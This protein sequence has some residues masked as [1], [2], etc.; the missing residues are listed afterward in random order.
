MIGQTVS[1]YRIEEQLGEGGMGIVYRAVDTK[2]DR[3]VA[4][5]FLPPRLSTDPEAKARF[6]QEAKAASGLDHPN[7][8]TIYDIGETDD[9]RLFIAMAFYDGQTLKYELQSGA[10]APEQAASIGAQ[11][12]DG[13]RK[14]HSARMVHRDIK[15]A[16]IMVTAEGRVKILDFGVAKLAG[17]ADLTKEGST[18]GTT[19][20]MSPEQARGEPVDARADLWSLGVLLYEMLSGEKPFGGEYEQAVFYSVLNE[21][22][23]PL[24]D[25]VPEE[26]ADVVSKL[27]AKSSKDRYQS[28]NDVL[29]ALEPWADSR[30]RSAV[31]TTASE[32]PPLIPNRLAAVAGGILVIAVLIWLFVPM[33]KNT[34]SETTETFDHV[35]VL[36]FTVQGDESIAYLRD[37]MVTLLSGMLDGAGPIRSIDVNR[38]RGYIE[39]HPNLVIDPEGG[40]TIAS[41]LGA[42]RYVIGTVVQAGPERQLEAT[43]Y[44]VNGAS[45]AGG[46]SSYT[47]DDT[48]MP[49]V[50]ALARQ[51]IGGQLENPDT[52]LPTLA[53]ET[54]TSVSA[55][56]N[57]LL[58]E[59]ALRNSD[60]DLAIELANMAIAADSTF[61]LAW[62]VKSEAYGWVPDFVASKQAIFEAYKYVDRLEGSLRMLIE[63]AHMFFSAKPYDAER[64][65]R[66][67]VR[68]YPNDLRALAGLAET[69]LH[70]SPWFL[71]DGDPERESWDLFTR[72]IELDPE[73]DEYEYH[74]AHSALHYGGVTL[75]DSLASVAEGDST[76]YRDILEFLS[77]AEDDPRAYLDSDPDLKSV[78]YNAEFAASTD[79][80]DIAATLI[81]YLQANKFD[82]SQQ[83]GSPVLTVPVYRSAAGQLRSEDQ[84]FDDNPSKELRT[85]QLVQRVF[86]AILPGFECCSVSLDELTDLVENWDAGDPEEYVGIYFTWHES[87]RDYLLGLIS[88]R[89]GD[90][91][92]LEESAQTFDQK[93]KS[94][95]PIV[96]SLGHELK[97]LVSWAAGDMAGALDHFYSVNTGFDWAE[98]FA[99]I[100][101]RSTTFFFI[102]EILKELGRY[103]DAVKYLE[104]TRWT[105]T[106]QFVVPAVIRQAEIYELEG[107]LEA[108]V[109]RYERVMKIWSGADAELQPVVDQAR[110]RR[111]EL[112]L[113]LGREPSDL[114]AP[115]SGP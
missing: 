51:L 43:L 71:K 63:G 85:H 14:A 65:L 110:A 92:A 113:R 1:Q 96:A 94:E 78:Y 18:V 109:G 54:T 95:G 32:A 115:T 19:A 100:P 56:K 36:P 48:F 6:V 3:D 82:F 72:I 17:G 31:H 66:R 70:Y 111:D 68:E 8:C 61:A 107:K 106:P 10:M 75:L 97:G 5:K 89:T 27:L 90:L 20:Y 77:A 40:K 59:A 39:R 49:A 105:G 81:N 67:M 41:E 86:E 13:L 104:Y 88:W 50:D 91:E 57:Y 98:R 101:G 15:P 12:A 83:A 37:G 64:I 99:T 23:Q 102:A 28:A 108:A 112:L 9:G 55:L 84:F 60:W 76:Y 74:L 46:Q 45:L 11:I 4:L 29:S 24:P 73:N 93:W 52:E 22:Q 7:I 103:D 2:L 114:P 34:P 38:V 35:A 44:G 58:A 87:V 26:L 16:N 33:G 53:S 30:V 47:G 25:S 42:N 62:F 69:L 79:N 21:T 80:L